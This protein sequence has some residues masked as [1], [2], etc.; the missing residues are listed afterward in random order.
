MRD[1]GGMASFTFDGTEIHF[2]EYG[3]GFPVLLI[4][5]GGM[6]SAASFW[7][8][9]PWNPIPQLSETFRV[10]AMDQRNAGR[11]SG[12][13]SADDSWDT[14]TRDQLALLDYLGIEKF[15][16]V[17]MCIGGPYVMGLIEAAP[18]R[19]SAGV[20]FQTIGLSHNREAFYDMFDAWATPLSST[21]PEI[22]EEVW[23]Q[24]RGNMY[25][26]DNLLFNVDETFV[27]SVKTPLLVFEG[28]DLY[29][30]SETS[31]AVAE[32]AQNAILVRDWQS[33]PSM[34]LA[35]KNFFDFLLRESVNET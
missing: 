30:P 16:A 5:P 8:S 20:L 2:D 28:N 29:H 19:V 11:S 26:S 1:N 4:A 31:V 15:H 17:G 35:A 7:E 3:T 12:P 21:R 13:I 22:A 32:L 27:K 10:I 34:A 6:K 25:D 14:Y 9:T 23:A 18:E 33:G 24:F